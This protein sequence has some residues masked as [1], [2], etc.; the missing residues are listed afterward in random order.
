MKIN[1]DI[2]EKE[3]TLSSNISAV[4][5][6]DVV[7]CCFSSPPSY[8]IYSGE[9]HFIYV[10]GSFNDITFHYNAY[11][12]AHND[13]Y[14]ISNC[15]DEA[16]Y[17]QCNLKQYGYNSKYCFMNPFGYINETNLKGRGMCNNPFYGRT[18]D[19]KVLNPN[20]PRRTSFGN[21]AFCYIEPSKNI[22]DCCAGPHT[23]NEDV[24]K[25]ILKSIDQTKAHGDARNIAYYD[26]VKRLGYNTGID[27]IT[28]LHFTREFSEKIGYV[29]KENN[30][31]LDKFVVCE[32]PNPCEY[33]Y[34]KEQNWKLDYE[35]LLPGSDEVVKLWK[36]SNDKENI[37][38]RVFVSSKDN[39]ISLNRF[40]SLGSVTELCENPFE[41]GPEFLGQYSA[42][43]KTKYYS[44][45]LWVVN[46]VVFDV[47]AHNLTWDVEEFLKWLMSLALNNMKDSIDEYRPI[48]DTL[49]ISNISEKNFIDDNLNDHILKY[50]IVKDKTLMMAHKEEKS[51]EIVEDKNLDDEALYIAVNEKTLLANGKNISMKMN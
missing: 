22:G 47:R 17:L 50:F 19:A 13:M 33:P 29:H 5:V 39:N 23:G 31:M 14:S 32:W 1:L 2:K 41:K 25:Y 6:E 30:E 21:H 26:G 7:R 38:V 36:I 3:W 28:D 43:F 24:N 16:A 11:Q 35:D 48:V 37:M 20:D 42:M 44:T 27:E 34:L 46:N 15:Y 9:P 49:D 4:T 40:L 45:Y 10:N 18:G 8:D 51:I 12:K